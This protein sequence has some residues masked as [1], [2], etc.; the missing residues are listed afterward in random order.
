MN[1]RIEAAGWVPIRKSE[2]RFAIGHPDSPTSN[3][4][5]VW[6][7]NDGSVY[8]KGRDNYS[9]V[10]LSLH[11]TGNWRFGADS[12]IVS[13]HPGRFPTG[14]DP[15]WER[16]RRPPEVMPGVTSAFRIYFMFDQLAVGPEFRNT[17]L[18]RKRDIVFVEPAPDGHLVVAGLW[19]TDDDHRL[20]AAVGPTITLASIPVPVT[21]EQVQVT[22]HLQPIDDNFR[23]SFA[24]AIAQGRN[25]AA[26]KGLDIPEGGRM[27]LYGKAPD[28][29]RFVTEANFHGQATA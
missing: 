29:S 17:T 2:V 6:T 27:L 19:L 4:W 15:V 22:V 5:K 11:P 26:H 8:L 24:A 21:H 3:S 10:K 12:Q 7:T 16:W 1:D 18:W 13:A 28:G 14:N 9:E 23:A 20:Q 25:R